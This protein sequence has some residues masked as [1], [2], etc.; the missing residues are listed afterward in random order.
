MSGEREGNVPLPDLNAGEVEEIPLFPLNMVLFPG[1][2]QPLHIFEERY[3]EMVHFCLET[4]T[5]FGVVWDRPQVGDEVEGLAAVGTSAAIVHVERLEEGRMNI[6]AVGRSR[7]RILAMFQDRPYL[8]ARVRRFPF[9]VVHELR[10]AALSNRVRD[11]LGTYTA[12]LEEVSGLELRMGDWPSQ[13]AAV[14]VLAAIALQVPLS[15][16][17]RLLACPTVDQMLATEVNLFRREEALL[18]HMQEMLHSPER[19]ER[20]TFGPFSLN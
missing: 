2:M 9:R 15:D 5:P 7:F 12:L 16:K 1:M 20:V 4:T 6:L 11:Y 10:A 14:A 8:M 13:L 19:L 18:T 17:Q 3:K